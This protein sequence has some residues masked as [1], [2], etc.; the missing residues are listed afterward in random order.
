MPGIV[1]GIRENNEQD[2]IV[3]VSAEVFYSGKKKKDR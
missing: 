1:L 3:L 2:D